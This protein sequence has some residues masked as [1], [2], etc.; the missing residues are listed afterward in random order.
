MIT[1]QVRLEA[2]TTRPDSQ[3]WNR[4]D[5]LRGLTLAGTAGLLGLN[6]RLVAAEPP[7]ETTRIRLVHDP[8]ICVTPQYL[9]EELLWADGFSEV[10]YV[11]AT[12]GFGARVVAAGG[13]DMMMEFAGV[14]LTRTDAGDPL[15]ML[16]GVQLGC[17]EVF[18]GA[19]VRAIRDLKGKRVAVLGEGTPEHVFLSS[20]VAYVGLDPR[21]D[22]RWESHP[23]EESMRLLDEDKIDAFAGFPP[24]PQEL[25][26]RRIGHLVLSTTTDRPWSQYFCCMV[27]AHRDFVRKHP[28]A[29]KR[30]L[31]AILKA[32][33]LCAANPEQ[34]ARFIVSRGYTGELDYATQALRE[35]PYA[36]WREYDPE[37]T[38]RFYALRLHEVGMIKSSPQKIIAQGTD[39][40]F[41]NEL[42]KEMKG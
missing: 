11:E 39:W 37:D 6:P 4:R 28:V 40:R 1:G 8:S 21:R 29:T 41:F 16:G 2:P 19:R 24:V 36:R 3:R 20:V 5:F 15:V 34:A 7:P 18:G 31:R 17:F 13:A 42:K 33:N 25:R 23:P 10:Q 30:A 9:A 27:G 22:I 26:A 12:D 14:Y 38:V 32:A 35:I